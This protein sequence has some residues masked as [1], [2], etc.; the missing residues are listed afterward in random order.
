MTGWTHIKIG[1]LAWFCHQAPPSV[2]WRLQLPPGGNRLEITMASG[3]KLD[4][5]ISG[6]CW[7]KK[8]EKP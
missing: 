1:R 4:F 3:R 2:R 6:G 5:K 8:Q 7:I